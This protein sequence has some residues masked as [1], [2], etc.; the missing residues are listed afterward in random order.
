[1]TNMDEGAFSGCSGLKK[2]IVND[3]AAWCAITF[4]D[5]YSNPLFYAHHLYSDEDSEITD[6]VIPSSVTS[7]GNGAFHDVDFNSVTS[8]IENPFPFNFYNQIFSKNTFMNATLYV[9]VGTIDKYK[10][11]EG[12][13][14]F[15]FMEEGTDGGNETPEVKK[16]EKPTISYKDARLYFNCE[17]EGVEY[18]SN[19]TDTDIKGYT[20]PTIDL[21]VTYHVSVY[22]T[23][24][25]YQNSD[26]A[27]GTLCWIEIDPQKEGISDL[28]TSAKAALQAMAVLIQANNGEVSIEGLPEG[29]KVSISDVS[30]MQHGMAQSHDGRAQISTSMKAGQ[31]AVVKIGNRAVK[32]LMK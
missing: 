24:S 4:F 22:A 3:I 18:I 1:L 2:V 29:T 16:C 19:I 15:L 5:Y 27:E 9:P 23:K 17:T 20:T 12:W 8:E 25:G 28:G 21:S 30:G 31:V 10:S 14:D 32:V 26:V 7:I 6:L 13:K 11:T